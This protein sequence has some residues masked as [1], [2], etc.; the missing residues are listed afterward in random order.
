M[1]RKAS[2]VLQVYVRFSSCRFAMDQREQACVIC[3]GVVASYYLRMSC[4]Q[5]PQVQLPELFKV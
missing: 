1:F 5:T 3:G 4:I 2:I